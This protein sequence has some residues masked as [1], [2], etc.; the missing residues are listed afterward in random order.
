M[1]VFFHS[2][3]RKGSRHERRNESGSPSPERKKGA[4]V[5]AKEASPAEQ[6][7]ERYL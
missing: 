7:L 2:A 5:E 3:A 1:V 6:H 4:D